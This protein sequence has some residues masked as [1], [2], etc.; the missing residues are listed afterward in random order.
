MQKFFSRKG[1]KSEE[2]YGRQSDR[3]HGILPEL[4]KD[5]P[6]DAKS[7]SAAASGPIQGS[8]ERKPSKRVSKGKRARSPSP[9]RPVKRA[10]KKLPELLKNVK[11]II[12]DLKPN[13]SKEEHEAIRARLEGLHNDAQS[14]HQDVQ[15]ADRQEAETFVSGWD[16]LTMEWHAQASETSRKDNTNY[17]NT[18]VRLENVKPWENFPTVDTI[19]SFSKQ[20]ALCRAF[21]DIGLRVTGSQHWAEEYFPPD[22]V[23]C[24]SEAKVVANKEAFFQELNSLIRLAC[25]PEGRGLHYV[26]IDGCEYAKLRRKEG[27]AT[28]KL[29][30]RVSFWFY[31]KYPRVN[32]KDKGLRKDPTMIPCLLVGDYKMSAKFTHA[33]LVNGCSG[34]R[35]N[36]RNQSQL[37]MN[38]IHDYM[39][40]HHNLFGYIITDTELIMFRRRNDLI[41]KDGRWGKVEYSPRIPVQAKKGQ[42]N[43]L[44]VLWYFHVKYAVME[45]DGGWKLPSSFEDYH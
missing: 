17:K 5:R 12:R 19:C 25:D 27:T 30:D 35:G 13:L 24:H 28:R 22:E 41:D 11:G 8:A 18:E 15:T 1:D 43:A 21:H 39:D 40:M 33:M 34:V 31:G 7:L 10:C 6:S 37:V 9:V 42:L 38:Q 44:M 4:E 45:L 36:D 29:P 20:P 32:S 3:R 26:K 2:K 16:R 14:I 23:G